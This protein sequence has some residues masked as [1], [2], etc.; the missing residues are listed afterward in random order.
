[1]AVFSARTFIVLVTLAVLIY[2]SAKGNEVAAIVIETPSGPVE[3][4]K[5]GENTPVDGKLTTW[6]DWS[7]CDAKCNGGNRSRTREYIKAVHGG[8]DLS[9]DER[10]NLIEN[11]LCNPQPCPE[12]GKLTTWSE[13]TTC[14]KDCGGGNRSR[15][16]EYIPAANGGADLSLDERA[17]LLEEELCNPQPCPEDGKWGEWSAW[18]ACNKSCGSGTQS[19]TRVYTAA[20]NGGVDLEDRNNN[21]ENRECNT[22][23]C[24]SYTAI[25]T[26]NSYNQT[27]KN[28][29]SPNG[30]FRF[31]WQGKQQI[32]LQEKDDNWVWNNIA[33]I[34][35]PR[36]LGWGELNLITG[37]FQLENYGANSDS[38]IIA[39]T[40]N[41]TAG[42]AIS[43]NGEVFFV[44][45]AGKNTGTILKRGDDK[46]IT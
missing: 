37:R 36:Y 39:A 42:I 12:D 31:L 29:Y 2:L 44:D 5:S 21:I 15:T 25:L 26:A 24:E 33:S 38:S 1:M 6:S 46:Q 32:Y 22:D 43:N 45:S 20:V 4:N 16:R 3:P 7:A 35:A 17:K 23:S 27:G 30:M 13:W 28:V 11:E 9:L 10:N 19:R 14:S 8:A 41:L 40:S 34:S 18:S